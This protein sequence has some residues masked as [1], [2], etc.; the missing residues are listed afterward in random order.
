MVLRAALGW[1]IPL[2]FSMSATADDIRLNPAHPA[3]YRVAEG[4]TLWDIAG[5][6]LQKP[7]QWPRV[8]HSNPAVKN[9]NY[10]YPG[11]ELA[12]TIVNGKPQISIASRNQATIGYEKLS[13]TIRETPLAQAI[14]LLPTT[15]IDQFLSSPKVVTEDELASAPYIL[16]FASEHLIAGA[17]DRVYVRTI[18]EPVGINYTIYRKGQAYVDPDSKETLGYEAEFIADTTLQKAGD[19]AT[20][21]IN[22][23]NS[24]VRAG[25]RL[26]P[27]TA[28]EITLNYFPRP[29]EKP[30]NGSIIS[31]LNGVSQIGQFHTVVLNKGAADDLAVGHVLDIY[32]HGKLITDPYAAEK[33][34]AVMLPDELA[35]SLMVYRV[36]KHVSYALIMQASQ[37]I[38]VLDKVQSP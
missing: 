4:D 1:L 33:G 12:F 11:D 5:K 23:T 17:G 2:I 6:F 19:P 30:L 36:F 31:V 3:Q 38:H 9:S 21:L 29:P 15:A 27:N 10:L 28:N 26:M 25:D 35:G 34:T 22:K 24:E 18:T 37:A 13:P 8:W 14:K 16:G 20:L 7:A 32:Q